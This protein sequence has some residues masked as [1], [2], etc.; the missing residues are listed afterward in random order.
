MQVAFEGIQYCCEALGEGKV[1]IEEAKQA[2]EETVDNAK[3]VYKEVTGLWG[4]FKN[5]LGGS[6]DEP[7]TPKSTQNQQQAALEPEK[8][9]VKKKV[10]QHIPDED[11]IV[12]RFI[13]NVSAWFDNH[14]KVSDWLEKATA[15]AY[16][17][18]VLDPSEILR[19]TAIQTKVD[20]AYLQLSGIMAK[21]PPQLGPLWSNFKEMQEKVKDAQAKRRNR[22]RIRRQQDKARR[23]EREEQ[24]FYRNLTVFYTVLIITYFWWYIWALWQNSSRLTTH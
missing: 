11:E 15:E 14:A 22:E 20:G 18:N 10:V 6:P 5:L 21:A 23:L 24:A 8:K 3:A 16:A 13:D 19:L 17:K 9:T 12:Q 4:W 2:V 7:V 1:R